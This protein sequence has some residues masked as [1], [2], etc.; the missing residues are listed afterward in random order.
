MI[1]ALALSPSLDVTYEVEELDGIQRPLSVHKVA[2]GKALN[3]ARAAACLGARVAAVAVLGGGAG[4]DVAAGARADGVDLHV[5]PGE[6]T[7][8]C[9]SVFSRADGRLTE[10]YERA[11]PVSVSA[12]SAAVDAAVRLAR[13]RP[14]WWLVSGGLPD[15]VSRGLVGEI[16]RRLRGA[17]VRVA[18]DTHGEPLHAAV[19]A[20]PDLVK[21]NR[22]EAAELVGGDAPVPDLLAAVRE[23]TG[24]LVVITDGA[25]GSWATDGDRVLRA[26]LTG[27]TGGFPVGSGDSFL[28]GLLVALDRGDDLAAALALATAAGTAN[29]QGPGAAVLDADLARRLA[30]QVTVS[31]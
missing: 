29:A 21:V 19:A 13:T 17:G 11:V 10:I 7:R 16:V 27:H 20:A 5:V 9:V 31:G 24:G 8:S 25:D 23:R 30:G 28:G 12:A 22:A 1:S 6:P 18:V 3:A 15:S 4:H 26:T 2:G 14:G